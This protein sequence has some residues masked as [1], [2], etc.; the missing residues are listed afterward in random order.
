MIGLVAALKRILLSLILGTMLLARL[1]RPVLM[2]GFVNLDTGRLTDLL[3]Q[4]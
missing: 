4:A 2:E 1:D 3:S